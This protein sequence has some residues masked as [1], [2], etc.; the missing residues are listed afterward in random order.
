MA[1]PRK[2]ESQK[3]VRQSLSF[4]P[5]Q[6]QRLQEY[7]TREERNVSWCVRKAMEQWLKDKGV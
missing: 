7:C 1:R 3:A 5:E 2:E 4:D 6:F